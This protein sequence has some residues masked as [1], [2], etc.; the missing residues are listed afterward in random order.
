MEKI[1]YILEVNDGYEWFVHGEYDSLEEMEYEWGRQDGLVLDE[2]VFMT[3]MR[4]TKVV[5]TSTVFKEW[6]SS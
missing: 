1:T 5:T 2:K 6:K 3:E 4:A